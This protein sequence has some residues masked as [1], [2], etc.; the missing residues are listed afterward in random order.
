MAALIV[1]LTWIQVID[2]RALRNSAVKHAQPRRRGPHDRGSIL[3]RDGSRARRVGPRRQRHLQ[4]RLPERLLR[5]THR[6]LLQ[7]AYGRAGIEAAENDV[8]SA[9]SAPSR[10]GATCSTRPW[11]AR[12]PATTSCSRS[13]ARSRRR[14]SKALDG[15]RGRGASC[16]TRARARCSRCRRTRATTPTTSEPAGRSSK[17]PIPAPRSSTARASRSTRRA[18]PSRSSR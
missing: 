18:R 14:P 4:A 1:N 17:L 3:T 7:P 15:R 6:R 2:A 13:T 5:R 9:A 12:S 16:S 10:R 11:A 8:L